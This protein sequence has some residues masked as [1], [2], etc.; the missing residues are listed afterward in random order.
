MRSFCFLPSLLPLCSFAASQCFSS[1]VAPVSPRPFVASVSFVEPLGAKREDH[2][3]QRLVLNL[4]W[5][6]KE[7]PVVDDNG[8]EWAFIWDPPV[9]GLSQRTL[10]IRDDTAV[11]FEELCSDIEKDICQ[12]RL[13]LICKCCSL[14]GTEE[15]PCR[16]CKHAVGLEEL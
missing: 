6:C 5:F 4:A 2:F 11:S 15:D 13:E 12:A 1:S 14:D 9:R 7:K 8:C 3:E 10:R 16:A